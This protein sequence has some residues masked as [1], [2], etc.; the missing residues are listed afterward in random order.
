MGKDVLSFGRQS[1]GIIRGVVTTPIGHY[2]YINKTLL[3]HL[4]PPEQIFY[5]F[6]EGND[7]NDT[8]RHLAYSYRSS[9]DLNRIYDPRYFRDYL[10]KS[11]VWSQD[12]D[13]RL[14]DN[15]FF[16]KFIKTMIRDFNRDYP[17]LWDWEEKR[18]NKAIIG[19]KEIYLPEVLQSPALEL[20]QEEI[21]MNIYIMEQCLLFLRDYF[22]GVP[23]SVVYLPSPLSV[24]ELTSETVSI[25]TYH[26]RDRI[27]KRDLVRKQSDTIAEQ[28]KGMLKK[29]DLD[30]IDP[31]MPL[32]EAAKDRHVYG[33]V[34]WWHFNKE[35]QKIIADVVLKFL[36][37]DKHVVSR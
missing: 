10:S 6:Y 27:Y 26:D 15:L 33:P 18:V 14:K 35:G 34:D 28:V 29:H 8:I 25:E 13:M 3:F 19:G 12:L 4:E 7:M 31:R 1:I 16:A 11:I 20:S 24:Y 9:Y 32:R 5:Y 37:Y 17:G 23:I 21:N 2:E 36:G 22:P 30:F